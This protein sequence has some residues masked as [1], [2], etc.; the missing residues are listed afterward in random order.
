M[1]GQTTDR[2]RHASEARRP[3]SGSR[4]ARIRD[5]PKGP[6]VGTRR[7]MQP[8]SA[9]AVRRDARIQNFW[10]RRRSTYSDRCRLAVGLLSCLPSSL[11]AHTRHINQP[12]E[13]RMNTTEQSQ[14]ARLLTSQRTGAPDQGISGDASVVTRAI[15]RHLR[16]QCSSARSSESRQGEPANLLD[17][18]AVRSPVPLNFEDIDAL[19]KPFTI[20]TEDELCQGSGRKSSIERTS[21]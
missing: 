7:R 14:H 13:A 18:A 5:E 21:H 19:S 11:A 10:E 9:T 20:P 15:G 1:A 12:M 2:I 16:A 8:T 3:G 17:S 4:A 6:R